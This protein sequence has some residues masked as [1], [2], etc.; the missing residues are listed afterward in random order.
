MSLNP[1]ER[2]S[3]ALRHQE[4]D[5]IPID[6]GGTVSSIHIDA[7]NN[8]LKYLGIEEEAA[9]QYDNRVAYPSDKILK[10]LGVDFRYIYPD[11]GTYW[12]FKEEK[13]GTVTDEWGAKYKQVGDYM[14]IFHNPLKGRSFEDVKKY[15][16]PDTSDPKRY[17]TLRE[18][19]LRIKNDSNYSLVYAPCFCIYYNLWGLRGMEQASMDLLIDPEISSYLLDKSTD[20][21]MGML[22]SSLD[23]IGDL[24][25]I[26]WVGDDWGTQTGPIISP[27]LFR[28]EMVPRHKKLISFAKKKT[29]AK[30]AYHSCGSVYWCMNDLIE[31][32]VEI[33]HPLQANAVGNENTAKIKKEFGNRMTFHGGIDNQG[34]FHLDK[35]I[36]LVEVLKKIKYLAPDGG[37]IFSSGHNIQPTCPPENIVALFECAKEF[38]TYPI[39]ID[40]INKEIEKL[41]KSLK[42]DR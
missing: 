24:I 35:R 32:G 38:G 15:K 16:F 31:M 28:K 37:Y 22:E 3:K 13:D 11:L 29:N 4:P 9:A 42:K 26:F 7:Y 12:T 2:V 27:D 20:W 17:K 5:R 41:E 30:C 21:A 6:S 40:K 25:D 1:D 23:R 14:E 36:M 39:D 8:L 10:Y 33:L 19:A 18:R 34:T